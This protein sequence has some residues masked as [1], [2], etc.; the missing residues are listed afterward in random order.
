MMFLRPAAHQYTPR[1]AGTVRPE[2]VVELAEDRYAVLLTLEAGPGETLEDRDLWRELSP[3]EARS[4]AA[5]LTHQADMAE[6]HR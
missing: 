5:M 4:L 2:I 3:D 6:R 1:D